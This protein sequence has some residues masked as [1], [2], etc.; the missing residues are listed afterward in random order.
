MAKD[1]LF[2]G[3]GRGKVGDVVFYRAGGQQITR[4]RN[5]QP[6]NPQTAIQL[7]QRVI[8]KTC[9]QAY[10]FFSPICDHSFQGFTGKTA[11]QSRFVARNTEYLRTIAADLIN[12]GDVQSILDSEY[13]NFSAKDS[14]GAQINRYIIS[15]GSLPEIRCAFNDNGFY[16]RPSTAT[17]TESSTYADVAAAFGL[18]R[19]D[20]LTF[21]MCTVDDTSST[22]V[23]S[24]LCYCRVILEPSTGDM[25]APFVNS[26]HINLPNERNEGNGT[27][28]INTTGLFFHRRIAA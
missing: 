12:S 14:F 8:L 20:Q 1:N 22:S 25:T 26:Y 10:S 23:F 18:Q 11:N 27:F 3:F 13:T 19:G 17:L 9:S 6:A 15:E 2:L 4:A 28:E 21:I 5:R 16:A 7:L 24:G